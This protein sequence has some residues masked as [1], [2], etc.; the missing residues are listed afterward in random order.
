[1][2]LEQKIGFGA[3][4]WLIPFELLPYRITKEK[5]ER[6]IDSKLLKK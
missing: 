4:Y 3:N 5:S 1:M 2:F 6:V